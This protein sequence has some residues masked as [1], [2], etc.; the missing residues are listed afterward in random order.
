MKYEAEGVGNASHVASKWF[1]PFQADL[2]L[3]K[4]SCGKSL[5]FCVFAPT[6]VYLAIVAHK[7]YFF[8]ML[9][10]GY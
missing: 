4:F 8:L 7:Y 3:S 5:S 2:L 10:G 6:L 9:Q 1:A